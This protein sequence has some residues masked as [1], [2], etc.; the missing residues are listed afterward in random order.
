MQKEKVDNYKVY[1]FPIKRIVKIQVQCFF[2]AAN[3]K[4]SYS[5][6]CKKNVVQNSIEFGEGG[7]GIRK[8]EE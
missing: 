7:A 1:Y 8:L 2:T 6:L 4:S 3:C 5:S